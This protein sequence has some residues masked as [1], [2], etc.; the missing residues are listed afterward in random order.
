MLTMQDP[1]PPPSLIV[2]IV[3]G[4]G[5]A[6]KHLIGFLVGFSTLMFPFLWLDE[7]AH[8]LEGTQQTQNSICFLFD[9]FVRNHRH[10][11]FRLPH[12]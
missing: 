9:L 6:I 2:R 11:N 12:C 5:I 7:A 10:S 1:S 4:V 8:A 3:R